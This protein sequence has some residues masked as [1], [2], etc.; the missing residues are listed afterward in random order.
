MS[1]SR[2]LWNS[3][4]MAS[5]K[6]NLRTVSPRK[7]LSPSHS[8]LASTRRPFTKVPLRLPMSSTR[9]RP[10]ATS[11]FTRA[12]RP[13]T[14]GSRMTSCAWSGSRPSTRFGSFNR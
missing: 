12:C 6:V 9:K 14:L 3:S 7:I 10:R 4:S 5:W 1:S 8:A 2:R 11:T 13:E